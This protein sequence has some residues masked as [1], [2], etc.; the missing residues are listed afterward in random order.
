MT[1]H[2]PDFYIVARYDFAG[3]VEESD[4]EDYDDAVACAAF[5]ASKWAW[6]EI[7]G[8]H[9]SNGRLDYSAV[10]QTAENFSATSNTPHKDR[11]HDFASR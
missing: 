8:V 3:R 6:V 7:I 2:P 10:E 5:D 1:S 11:R 4:F 9:Y